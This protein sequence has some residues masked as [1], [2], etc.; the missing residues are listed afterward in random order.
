M[1]HHIAQPYRPINTNE[2]M[3]KVLKRLL[4][5]ISDSKH[6]A[7]AY[8]NQLI[9]ICKLLP[10]STMLSVCKRNEKSCRTLLSLA[11]L[12]SKISKIILFGAVLYDKSG[13]RSCWTFSDLQEKNICSNS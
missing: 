3:H 6:F 4:N 8:V 5:N 1:H 11:V 9:S 2:Y 13:F 7:L 10:I 12:S